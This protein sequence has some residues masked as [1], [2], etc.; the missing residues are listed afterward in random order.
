MEFRIN[1]LEIERSTL[2]L[3]NEW[4]PP[5]DQTNHILAQ[6]EDLKKEL[7]ESYAMQKKEIFP[8]QLSK[9]IC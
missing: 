3:E 4:L 9:T 2:R 1:Q 6:V 8:S 5:E 7:H